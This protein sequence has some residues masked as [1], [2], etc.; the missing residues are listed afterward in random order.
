MTEQCSAYQDLQLDQDMLRYRAVDKDVAQAAMN[1]M[2]RLIPRPETV[3]FSPPLMLY[4]IRQDVHAAAF[5]G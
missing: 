2:R 1:V 5:A 3:D 4:M